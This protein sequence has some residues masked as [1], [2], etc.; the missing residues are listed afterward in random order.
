MFCDDLSLAETHL[1]IESAGLSII[2]QDH[3]QALSLEKL[4]EQ[5][6]QLLAAGL[7]EGRQR[8]V[9]DEDVRP[10]HQAADEIDAR[11][12]LRRQEPARRADLMVEAD[13]LDVLQQAEFAARPPRSASATRPWALAT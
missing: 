7:V 1:N 4:E 2:R 13:P 9:D 12:L 8:A 10:L 11:P 6:H 5:F 3:E